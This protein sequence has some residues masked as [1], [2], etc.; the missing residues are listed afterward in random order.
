MDV[1][2]RPPNV[3][4]D[5]VA[6]E[7]HATQATSQDKAAVIALAALI[8]NW[9]SL[10]LPGHIWHR[11]SFELK[12]VASQEGHRDN[13]K[14]PHRWFIEGRMRV[15]DCV[16]DEWLAVWLLREASRQWDI[17]VS[18]FDTDGEFL[19]IEAADSIPSWVTPA[20]AAN[21]VWIH[22]GQLHIIS[23]EDVSTSSQ[24]AYRQQS[25]YFRMQDSDDEGAGDSA[26][27][28]STINVDDAVK[29]VRSADE[30][31]MAS[32]E[33]QRDAFRRITGYPGLARQHIQATRVHLPVDIAR[34]LSSN[35]AL[36]QKAAEAFYTRD[37][38]QLRAANRMTRFP[39]QPATTTTVHM[40]RTAY[41]QLSGQQFFPPKPFGHFE[42]SRDSPQW[43]W[44]DIGMKIACGFEMLYQE[45]KGRSEIA[46]KGIVASNEAF[47][48]RLDALKRDAEYE[49]YIAQLVNARYFQ[50]EMEGS[51]SWKER[52]EHAAQAF[53]DSLRNDDASR[54]SFAAQVNAALQNINEG[55]FQAAQQQQEDDDSWMNVTEQD[56]DTLMDERAGAAQVQSSTQHTD[57]MQVDSDDGGH[58]EQTAERLQRLAKKVESFVEG[59]GDVEGALF[60]DEQMSNS[61]TD[62]ELHLSENLGDS[63]SE[64]ELDSEDRRRAKQEAM[65]RL[66]PPLADGEYGKMPPSF[67]A[68]SQRVTVDAEDESLDTDD[69]PTDNSTNGN[70]AS[71][72]AESKAIRAPI[73]PR[74][75]FDGV[76]SDDDS[77]PEEDRLRPDLDVR[78]Q[79]EEMDEEEE[80]AESEED[81]PALE[82]EDELDIDM[83][84]EQDEF[85]EF[86]RE[87]LGINDDMWAKIVQDRVDRG[88]Y[89]PPSSSRGGA[90]A[91]TMPSQPLQ[92]A[93]DSNG[94]APSNVADAQTATQIFDRQSSGDERE[95]DMSLDT[96]EKVMDAMDREL[97][98][99]RAAKHV[100]TTASTAKSPA[101]HGAKGKDKAHVEDPP[102]AE[103]D[104]A[105]IEAAMEEEFR[106]ALEVGDEDGDEALEPG[107]YGM[108]KNFLESFKAQ[109]GLAGPVGALAGRLDPGWRLPRDEQGQ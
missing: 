62:G 30:R 32:N 20:N 69:R 7:L 3:S 56:V 18:I 29:L 14:K 109:G 63:D 24:K 35:P 21:R 36:V 75:R 58:V 64:S 15:G 4:E 26:E 96:F 53:V 78:A 89:I 104:F 94:S 50:G 1:F 66:V 38:L 93:E 90:A 16:D 86:A 39:P 74:D 34:A 17:V 55:Q 85:L 27:E 87:A 103:P 19:L 11:D 106:A 37:A 22:R 33:V 9:A 98:M 80:G 41:A 40:S 65:D 67:Y 92:Q 91:S 101:T 23:L 88:A 82:G 72:T 107:D 31:T 51:Q 6:Y 54:P 57:T 108:I 99:A 81:R 84:V 59:K 47:V 102:S 76:D 2:S 44:R 5:T 25:R 97:A 83:E 61:D 12:V 28:S 70:K 49:K 68:N 43:R 71:D 42:E 48:A 77:D 45:S 100:P 52:E 60:D 13:S 95:P 73:L 46:A 10:Q 79:V 8:Q 105:D